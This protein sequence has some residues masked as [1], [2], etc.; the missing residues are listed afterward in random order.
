MAMVP[1][2]ENSIHK[3]GMHLWF[4]VLSYLLIDLW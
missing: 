4:E 3:D 2:P 1:D